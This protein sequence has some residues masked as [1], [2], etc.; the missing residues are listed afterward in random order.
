MT[1]SRF[2]TFGLTL[3]AS[4]AYF[5]CG[6]PDDGDGGD[7][8]GNESIDPGGT[9]GGFD[10]DGGVPSGGE[11]WTNE[12]IINDDAPA[13]VVDL[14]N[15]SA[16]GAGCVTEPQEGAL[17]PRNWLRPRFRVQGGAQAYMVVLSVSGVDGIDS[18]LTG[19]GGPGG[20][21]MPDAQWKWLGARANTTPITV[22]AKVRAHNGAGFTET[23]STFLVAPVSA[24]G[25]MV[26]WAS[27]ASKDHVD[28]SK[29]V[30]FAVGEEGTVDALLTA[31]VAETDLREQGYLPRNNAATEYK[32]D[33]GTTNGKATCIG[34]H[35]STPDGSAVSFNTGYPWNGVVAS[36]EQA[37]VGQRP[38][39]VTG[40]G[41][42]LLNTPF[43]GTTTF[44]KASWD[45]GK[46]FA[47]ATLTPWA[48]TPYE[49]A[50]DPR[51]LTTA[52]DLIWV[53]LA[54]PGDGVWA[55]QA[56]ADTGFVAQEG[57]G[58]GKL[59]RTGDTRAAATPNWSPDGL[60]VAYT[61]AERVAGSHIGGIKTAGVPKQPDLILTETTET[62]I[63]TVPFSDGN[64]G[65][66]RPLSGAATAGVAEYYPD[67]SADGKFI[68]FNRAPSTAGY[69]YYRADA[70]VHI[71]PSAGGT[72]HRLAA[73][74]A[75]ACTAQAAGTLINSWPKWS[76]SVE[77]AN[78]VTY[79]WV[80]FSS[81]RAYQEQF[82]VPR[83]Y[84]TP[85]ALETRSSQLYLAA[86]AVDAS[87]NITSYPAVYIWNQTTDTSNLTPAWDEF[88]I[89]PV[90]LK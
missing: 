45:S 62:D 38:S 55:D 83:D 74:D 54:A 68:A 13:N 30:G 76:P 35:T 78:G 11:P 39:Y 1:L 86:V 53:D 85:T 90:V 5:A 75:P 72:A 88:K 84:Y 3:F 42:R 31:Q 49:Y 34:C 33:G 27:N 71:I 81:A 82:D 12:P 20:W 4:I 50:Y 59:A 63:Y 37:T 87:G 70:D 6:A 15:G 44:S 36:V 24:G 2:T 16:S 17:M 29:L 23:T 52:A 61:S 7:S 47:V 77:G 48:A 69:I 89:P 73:N 56:A 80:I 41:A 25:A 43:I 19:Y 51:N 26:Y 32:D 10:F 79:Y 58:W 22:T 67:Y 46:R 21:R 8:D 64:G 9:G 40:M 65:A 60:T 57:T 14:F 66:A 18:D 28:S